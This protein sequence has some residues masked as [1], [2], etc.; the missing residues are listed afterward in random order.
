[1]RRS[2]P[3]VLSITTEIQ[4]MKPKKGEEIHTCHD[5]VVKSNGLGSDPSS[6]LFLAI[7]DLAVILDRL[8]SLSEPQ[9]PQLRIKFPAL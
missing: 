6:N 9:G 7:T 8:I 3:C 1:M 5:L 2:L 4:G